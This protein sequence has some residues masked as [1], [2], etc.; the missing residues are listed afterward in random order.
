MANRDV[1][2]ILLNRQG[3]KFLLCMKVLLIF[4]LKEKVFPEEA[5]SQNFKKDYKKNALIS[6]GRKDL[7]LTPCTSGEGEKRKIQHGSKCI[8]VLF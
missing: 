8:T 4:F 6:S 7:T 5:K 2:R 1:F 3:K